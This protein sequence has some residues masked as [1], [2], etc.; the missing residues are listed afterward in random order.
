MA[1]ATL[2]LIAHL[3]MAAASGIARRADQLYVIAD[4]QL[5]LSVYDLS[6]V[7]RQRIALL[8][9]ELPLDHAAR[10]AVKP[11]F[12]ALV[13]LPDAS[14]LMLG[15]GSTAQRRAGVWLQFTDAGPDASRLDLSPLYTALAAELPELNIEGGAVHGPHLY[16]CSRGNGAL[17][18]NALLQLD[19][20]R[21][22][23][24]L[25]NGRC[26][27]DAC[28]LGLQR[29]HLDQLEG[30]PLSLTDLTLHNGQL[31]F[32][33]AAEASANTYDDGA[34]AGSVIGKLS[35][36]GQTSE[37][38]TLPQRLKIEG[39]CSAGP[40]ELYAVADADDPNAHAPL[41]VIEPWQL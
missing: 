19:L 24:T 1:Q 21:A 2:R 17:R 12:E 3:D 14:L 13:V 27:N 36:A 28:I 22:L 35:T 16:L 9:G 33:A 11:D 4:D 32:S 23:D 18:D 10:K 39:I 41:F 15:S 5:D 7:H 6:G 38:V 25:R 37:V 34:C 40:R 30:V 8:P 20:E 31:A 29:V 26:L